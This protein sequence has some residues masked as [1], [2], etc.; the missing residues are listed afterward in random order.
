VWPS[1]PDRSPILTEPLAAHAGGTPHGVKPFDS[2]DDAGY[3][4]ILAWILDGLP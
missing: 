2:T 3:Q 4:V 1:P